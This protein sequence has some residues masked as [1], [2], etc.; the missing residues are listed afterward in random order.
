MD[1]RLSYLLDREAGGELTP[2][3]AR[4]LARRR[5]VSGTARREAAAWARVEEE[6]RG[7]LADAP[8][9][10]VERIAARVT[11]RVAHRRVQRPWVAAA[12]LALVGGLAWAVPGPIRP[13]ATSAPPEATSTAPPGPWTGPPVEVRL[14]ERAE[15]GGLV[16]IDF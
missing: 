6:L 1:A 5:S 2:M 3:E 9:L 15:G 14:D 11:Q 7:A 12:S 4:E 8:P 16:Q 10:A 13:T